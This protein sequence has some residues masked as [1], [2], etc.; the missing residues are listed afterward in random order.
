MTT[1]VQPQHSEPIPES[2]ELAQWHDLQ[3][4]QIISM[5]H[6]WDNPEDDC[7][8]DVP[9]SA[10]DVDARH[11]TPTVGRSEFT[12]PGASVAGDTLAKVKP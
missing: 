7:W 3:N 2:E 12:A 8:N 10:D 5:M 9:L 4:A 11:A 6:V 1:L